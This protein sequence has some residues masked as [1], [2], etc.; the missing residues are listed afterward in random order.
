MP[1][2][3]RTII[4]DLQKP[5]IRKGKI[6][7]PGHDQMIEDF[8]FQELAGLFELLGQLAAARQT[9]AG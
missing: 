7:L 3:V 8:Y 4:G 2:K 5:L 9:V 6:T 1:K